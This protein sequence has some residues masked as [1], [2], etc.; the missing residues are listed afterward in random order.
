[1]HGAMQ[2][3]A[4]HECRNDEVSEQS[5]RTRRARQSVCEFA[6][7]EREIE[8]E[9]A[10]VKEKSTSKTTKAKASLWRGRR[11]MSMLSMRPKGRILSSS[12]RS[13]TAPS[14]PS[15]PTHTTCST[16]EEKRGGRRGREG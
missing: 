3:N 9:R 8:K 12:M 6:A 13:V 15:P 16:A 7:G 1:M 10:Q 5:V 11:L 14:G 2:C 4:M